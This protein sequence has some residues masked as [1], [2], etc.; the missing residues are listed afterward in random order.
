MAASAG[1]QGTAGTPAPR[2]WHC[3]PSRHKPLPPCLPPPWQQREPPRGPL[4]IDAQPRWDPGPAALPPFCAA[5]PTLG[6]VAAL[7]ALPPCMRG[8]PSLADVKGYT[9]RTPKSRQEPRDVRL[10]FAPTAILALGGNARGADS[11]DSLSPA[12]PRL[13]QRLGGSLQSL[14]LEIATSCG[15]ALL[16]SGV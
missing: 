7:A 14:G 16:A 10:S 12:R 8:H 15:A 5:S 9:A 4:L 6:S 2:G 11:G 3:K 13:P 1:C